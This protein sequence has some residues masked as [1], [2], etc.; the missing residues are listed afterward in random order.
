MELP[1][2]EFTEHQ[3]FVVTFRNGVR[4]E[5]QPGLAERQRIGLRIVREQGS[6]STTEYCA[7]TGAPERTGLRDLQN[8]VTQGLLVVRQEAGAAI[9]PAII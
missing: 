7:A 9:L 6:I 4:L 2:P 8:L 5:D 1:D 3:D